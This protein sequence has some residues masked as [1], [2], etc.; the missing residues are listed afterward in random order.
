M[1][2]V[3]EVTAQSDFRAQDVEI[4]RPYPDEIPWDLLSLGE[5]DEQALLDNTEAD[6]IRVAKRE[7]QAIGAYVIQPESSTVYVLRNLVVE[8]TWRRRGLGR[9]L[10]GHAIGISESKGAREILARRAPRDARRLFERTGFQPDG[11][12]LRLLLMPE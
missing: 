7:D 9:W 8:P 3:A 12:D 1:A 4:Y 11:S 10:L 5:P 2:S 6:Y